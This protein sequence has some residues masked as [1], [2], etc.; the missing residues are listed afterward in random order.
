MSTNPLLESFIALSDGKANVGWGS[1]P[2][3]APPHHPPLVEP[4][5]LEKMGGS[6]GPVAG[7]A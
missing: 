5:M 7:G 4:E 3:N 1:T 6:R 2:P